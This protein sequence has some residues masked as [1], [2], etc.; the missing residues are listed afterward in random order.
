MYV[1][2]ERLN[3]WRFEVNE[4]NTNQVVCVSILKKV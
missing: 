3:L 2:L 1:T 4:E